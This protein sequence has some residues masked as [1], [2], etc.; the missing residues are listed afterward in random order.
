MEGT[1]EKS[2]DLAELGRVADAFESKYGSHFEAPDGTWAGL[3]D[4]IRRAEALVY[5]VSPET[6]FGFG[7]GRP[8][9]QTKWDFS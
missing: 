1:A 3:G 4:A 5:R 7:K 6:G 9:S 2:S 8:F